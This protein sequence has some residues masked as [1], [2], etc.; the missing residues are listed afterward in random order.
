MPDG[1]AEKRSPVPDFTNPREV[2]I[3]AQAHQDGDDAA[4]ARLLS[5]AKSTARDMR[6]ATLGLLGTAALTVLQIILHELHLLN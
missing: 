6:R 4:H 5:F 2:Q 1:E 3:W